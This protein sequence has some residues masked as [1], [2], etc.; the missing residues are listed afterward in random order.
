MQKWKTWQGV[1]NGDMSATFNG[2]AHDV[3]G[4]D[5]IGAEF[6]WTGTP[7]GTLKLQASSDPPTDNSSGPPANV[8]WNDVP[9]SM[10]T[11]PSQPAGGPSSCIVPVLNFP[12]AWLRVVYTRTSGTGTLQAY[13]NGKSL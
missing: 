6:V 1:V 10:A 13:F 3:R 2:P 5:N 9:A 8:T 12:W 11:F 4:V 7:T